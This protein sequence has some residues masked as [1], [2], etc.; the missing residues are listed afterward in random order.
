[1]IG[2][3][4]K[5][6]KVINLVEIVSNAVLFEQ[7]PV[8]FLGLLLL[9]ADSQ[10]FLGLV[11]PLKFVPPVFLLCRIQAH[12]FSQE[13]ELFLY[14]LFNCEVLVAYSYGSRNILR[15][16]YLFANDFSV[17]LVIVLIGLNMFFLLV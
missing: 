14:L 5:G 2:S 7:L 8:V 17:P 3:I 1:M 16:F 4:V 15:S 6:A 13:R 12:R 11:L 9:H 10:L